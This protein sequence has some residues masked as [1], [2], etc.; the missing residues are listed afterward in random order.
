M[1]ISLVRSIV[2]GLVAL[3]VAFL[4]FA[5]KATWTQFGWVLALLFTPSPIRLDP[6]TV[7]GEV[8]STTTSI[9]VIEDLP[10]EGIPD[11]TPTKPDLPSTDTL[12]EK[13]PF[14]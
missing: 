5:G 4:V 12:T 3:A 11:E 1:S 14:R 9:P 7:P 13:D 2:A 8:P 6:K 10:A